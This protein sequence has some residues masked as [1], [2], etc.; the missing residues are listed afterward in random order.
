MSCSLLLVIN[1]SSKRLN[2]GFREFEDRDR[3]FIVRFTVDNSY[4]ALDYRSPAIVKLDLV[5]RLGL[6][7]NDKITVRCAS[8]DYVGKIWFLGTNAEV[9][10]QEKEAEQIMRRI[11]DGEN[12]NVSD[13]SLNQSQG[14]AR[15]VSNVPE[16]PHFSM[17]MDSDS[18]DE[19]APPPKSAKLE[20]SSSSGKEDNM[21]AD[22]SEM[23]CLLKESIKLFFVLNG[24]VPVFRKK[25]CSKPFVVF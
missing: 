11:E 18:E 4:V 19:L 5:E 22:I 14:N 13:I 15:K 8:G 7:K 12:I 9:K 2:K 20:K 24:H 1:F 23:V 3:A 17:E 25:S 16:S 10:V 21:S 6:A